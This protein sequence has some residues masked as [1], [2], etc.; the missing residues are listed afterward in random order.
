M[1]I[2]NV[3]DRRSGEVRSIEAATLEY[4]KLE[5]HDKGRTVIYSPPAGNPEAGTI[6]S[7]RDGMVFVRYGR[8]ETAAAT[9][10]KYLFLVPK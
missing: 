3:S 5:P 9:N 7:W 8:G 2:H 10:P 4:D 6:S 1:M